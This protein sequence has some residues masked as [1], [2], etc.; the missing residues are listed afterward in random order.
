MPLMSSSQPITRSIEKRPGPVAATATATVAS[1]SGN[2]IPPSPLKKPFFQWTTAIA[3]SITTAIPR[4]ASG[5]RKP[6]ANES[7]LA[8]ARPAS[9]AIKVGA[10]QPSWPKKPAV[11]RSPWPPN[12]PKSFCAPC[13]NIVPPI[14]TR[15]SKSPYDIR[16]SSF[17]LSLSNETCGVN[18]SGEAM[19]VNAPGSTARG[20]FVARSRAGPAVSPTLDASG[21][22]SRTSA[23]SRWGS[24]DLT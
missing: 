18:Y 5:V 21:P 22:V 11:P 6:A 10:R 4:A 8:S 3:F 20:R 19:N 13:E 1:A 2:S 15:K 23:S 9:S 16:S 17:R 12:Q 14:T 24:R 7:P